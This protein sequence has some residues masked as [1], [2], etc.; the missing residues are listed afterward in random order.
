M[1][2]EPVPAKVALNPPL[3]L[4]VKLGSIAR[5]AEEF[6]SPDGH[7]FDRHAIESLL[8]D[9]E[10]QTWMASADALALLPVKRYA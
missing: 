8:A 1:P 5:H 2:P 4:I 6:L 7:D 9:L 3:S 10:V